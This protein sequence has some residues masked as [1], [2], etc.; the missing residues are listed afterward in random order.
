MRLMPLHLYLL[1]AASHAIVPQGTGLSAPKI[2]THVH[3]YPDFYKEASIA[4]GQVP[5]PNGNSY[6]PV[7]PHF[8]C[9][10]S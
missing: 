8:F 7:S 4:A 2:D 1:S 3:I 6:H 5:G 10:S 9:Y